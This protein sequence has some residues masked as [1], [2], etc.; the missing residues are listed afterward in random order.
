AAAAPTP[1]S[2]EVDALRNQVAGLQAQLADLESDLLSARSFQFFASISE[3]PDFESK[4]RDLYFELKSISERLSDR[5]TSLDANDSLNRSLFDESQVHDADV[6]YDVI[7]IENLDFEFP[8]SHISLGIDELLNKLKALESGSGDSYAEAAL[9]LAQKESKDLGKA[10]KDLKAAYL[11][12]QTDVAAKERAYEHNIKEKAARLSALENEMNGQK[13]RIPDLLLQIN[14]LESEKDEI[15]KQIHFLKEDNHTKASTIREL[16]KELDQTNKRL[17]ELESEHA[18]FKELESNYYH[19]KAELDE[20]RAA[21]SEMEDE[22]TDKVH[23]IKDLD[24]RVQRLTAALDEYEAQQ[25]STKSISVNGKACFL[26]NDGKS[27]QSDLV[28]G[29]VVFVSDLKMT[30]D[31]SSKIVYKFG[32]RDYTFDMSRFLKEE[33][34]AFTDS[35][36]REV[37]HRDGDLF[38]RHEGGDFKVLPDGMYKSQSEHSKFVHDLDLDDLEFFEKS[39][40]DGIPGY[41][42]T[43]DTGKRRKRAI[44]NCEGYVLTVKDGDQEGTYTSLQDEKNYTLGEGRLVE[45]RRS[46]RLPTIPPSQG[47]LSILNTKGQ[48]VGSVTDG[49]GATRNS[50]FVEGLADKGISLRELI[51][52]FWESIDSE[53]EKENVLTHCKRLL[54]SLGVLNAAGKVLS[55]SSPVDIVAAIANH[56][57]KHNTEAHKA[58]LLEYAKGLGEQRP[59][60]AGSRPG[61]AA[62][63]T[64]TPLVPI[65]ENLQ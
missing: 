56:K 49:N 62:T 30:V 63:P 26:T 22:L 65:Q 6:A 48:T 17:D 32:G 50:V 2:S 59:V 52:S 19:L 3:N 41:V 42:S 40:T 16:E 54:V 38:V 4:L 5:A 47:D 33:T 29:E 34:V 57:H 46:R 13:G 27:M 39:S 58:A 51:N 20:E 61:S 36:A 11:K 8:I 60:S 12:L 45:I 24:C 43:T 37:S 9:S 64:P 31:G 18:R 53:F 44:P 15:F 1:D 35:K 10:L 21:R 25:V 55:S 7:P 14:T 28:E 23:E